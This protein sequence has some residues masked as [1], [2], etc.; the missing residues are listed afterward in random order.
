MNP[1]QSTSLQSLCSR[2]FQ[3]TKATF[4]QGRMAYKGLRGA[5]GISDEV[6]H[7]SSKRGGQWSADSIVVDSQVS[8]A[9]R[10]RTEAVFPEGLPSTSTCLEGTF[11]PLLI[12]FSRS[13]CCSPGKKESLPHCPW[14][15]REGSIV[16]GMALCSMNL[17]RSY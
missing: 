2:T 15:P 6:P 7:P 13:P 5:A 14:P 8:A 1:L 4:D 3:G 17:T 10:I 12:L 11:Q 16:L 9:D